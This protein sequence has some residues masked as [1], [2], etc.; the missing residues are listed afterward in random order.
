VV[1]L[2]NPRNVGYGAAANRGVSHSRADYVLV[3]NSD[4]RVA[5]GTMQQLSAYLDD[6]PSVAVVGPPLIAPS[7]QPQPSCKPLPGLLATFLEESGLWPLLRYA[8]VL[9]EAYPPT[10]SHAHPR[11]AAWIEG[12]ALAIR[13]SA[14]QAIGGFDTSFFMYFEEVDLCYRLEQAGWQVH[15][16]PAGRV[17][18]MGGGSARQR[19]ADMAVQ[20]FASRLHFYRRH[21]SRLK[22]ASLVPLIEMIVLVRWLVG[23]VRI[24]LT[25]DAERRLELREEEVAWRRVLRGEWLRPPVRTSGYR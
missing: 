23:P 11:R 8:P 2:A 22:Q 19:R 7:G 10:A 25:R 15:F 9:R 14:F 13:R 12:A 18:H 1:L 21:Y 4:T 5:P 6:H 20:A 24:W 3:L 17:L 16:A